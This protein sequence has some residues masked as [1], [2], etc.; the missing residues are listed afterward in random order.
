MYYVLPP[1]NMY[2]KHVFSF[3]FPFGLRGTH[4]V[5]GKKNCMDI[6]CEFPFYSP[7]VRLFGYSFLFI[8]NGYRWQPFAVRCT[9]WIASIMHAHQLISCCSVAVSLLAAIIIV[10]E[11]RGADECVCCVCVRRVCTFELD[12]RAFSIRWQ[13]SCPF[14]FYTRVVIMNK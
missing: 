5:R 7:S 2:S 4:F 12:C 13:I 3:P 10:I 1:L 8:N 14:D 6:S 11:T 9:F